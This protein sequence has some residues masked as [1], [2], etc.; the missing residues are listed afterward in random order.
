[1]QCTHEFGV[2]FFS[3]WVHGV[4]RRV[5]AVFG[6]RDGLA[7]V[8]EVEGKV[9]VDYP[10]PVFFGARLNRE[11]ARTSS[12]GADRSFPQRPAKPMVGAKGCFADL[13]ASPAL[14]VTIV[15]NAACPQPLPD[16]T[17]TRARGYD[18]L[19]LGIV[20]PSWEAAFS[21]Q[22]GCSKSPQAINPRWL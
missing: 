8:Y 20:E 9:G 7:V 22:Y 17:P 21:V 18:R 4:D 11:S 14:L 15:P 16:P 13:R 2:R 10:L 6:P 5:V 19:A 3:S 12:R 1:M